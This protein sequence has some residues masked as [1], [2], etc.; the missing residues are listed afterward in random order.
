MFWAIPRVLDKAWNQRERATNKLSCCDLVLWA[1]FSVFSG[2]YYL[3]CSTLQTVV[4][5]LLFLFPLSDMAMYTIKWT[6]LI[7]PTFS[8]AVFWVS[9][10]NRTLEIDQNIKRMVAHFLLNLMRSNTANDPWANIAKRETWSN[11]PKVHIK[12]SQCI[13][14][15]SDK[16]NYVGLEPRGNRYSYNNHIFLFYS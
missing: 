2:L 15:V 4:F 7:L 3:F 12:V 11:H 14:S 9:G 10:S 6:H 1:A 13:I 8:F 16:E 5:F